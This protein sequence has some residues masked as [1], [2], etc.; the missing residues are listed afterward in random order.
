M[1]F[2]PVFVFISLPAALKTRIH[3]VSDSWLTKPCMIFHML[4]F[5]PISWFQ[6]LFQYSSPLFVTPGSSSNIPKY[7]YKDWWSSSSSP[8]FGQ[9]DL[10]YPGLVPVFNILYKLFRLFIQGSIILYLLFSY[11]KYVFFVNLDHILLQVHNTFIELYVPV[12]KFVQC[13][14]TQPA[15]ICFPGTNSPVF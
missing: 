9:T 11:R 15:N 3:F 2:L 13:Q 4:G 6:V 8:S 1:F 7:T 14:I 12:V 10:A 5:V